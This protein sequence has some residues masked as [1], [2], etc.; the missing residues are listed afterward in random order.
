[1][2]KQVWVAG[3]ERFVDVEVLL[4]RPWFRIYRDRLSLD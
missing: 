3:F 1:M 4:L 2:V